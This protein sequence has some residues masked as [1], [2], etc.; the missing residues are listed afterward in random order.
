MHRWY[1]KENSA[2]DCGES[3]QTVDHI[4]MDCPERKFERNTKELIDLTESA[5]EWITNLN[6]EL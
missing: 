6:I 4:I 2:C 1:L 5:V 3:Q